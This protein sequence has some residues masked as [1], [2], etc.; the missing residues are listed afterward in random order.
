[1]KEKVSALALDIKKTFDMMIDYNIIRGEKYII[2]T[3][4]KINK[5]KS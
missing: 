2:G 5:F 1:M 4:V 3:H